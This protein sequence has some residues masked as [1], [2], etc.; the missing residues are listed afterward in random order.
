LVNSLIHKVKMVDNLLALFDKF[1]EVYHT[2]SE[3]K[4]RKSVR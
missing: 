1:Y 2:T 4:C 3:H